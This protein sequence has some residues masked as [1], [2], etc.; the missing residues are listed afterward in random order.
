[1]K[2]GYSSRVFNGVSDGYPD[3]IVIIILRKT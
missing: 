1:M 2:V 3:L